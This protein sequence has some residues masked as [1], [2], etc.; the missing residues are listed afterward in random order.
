MNEEVTRVALPAD[1]KTAHWRQMF[2]NAPAPQDALPWQD[3][4]RQH[5][6]TPVWVAVATAVAALLLLVA[7]CPPFVQRRSE[8]ELERGKVDVSRLLVWTV[9]IFVLVLVLPLVT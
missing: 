4:A 1:L 6:R 3:R 7:L 2:Q 5:A 9:I 8:H